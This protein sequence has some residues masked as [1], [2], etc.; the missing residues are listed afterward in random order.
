MQD[1][2]LGQMRRAQQELGFTYFVESAGLLGSIMCGTHEQRMQG[3]E[4]LWDDVRTGMDAKALSSAG[5]APLDA[6]FRSMAHRMFRTPEIQPNHW[7]GPQ[8]HQDW[9]D[10]IGMARLN[11][12]FLGVERGLGRRR[13]LPDGQG[14]AWTGTDGSETVFAF[15]DFTHPIASRAEVEEVVAGGTQSADGRLACG[16]QRIYRI[17]PR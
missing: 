5:I 9:Y 7:P 16:T 13:L 6:Y 12:A 8:A 14:V 2:E 17:R 10:A 11:H 4:W 3:E 1:A 15:R